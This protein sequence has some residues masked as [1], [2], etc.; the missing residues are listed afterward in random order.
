MID[1]LK[2]FIRSRFFLG[3]VVI[4]LQFAIL[5]AILSWLFEVFV[6]IV[7][8]A[9][10]FY[11]VV[12]LYILNRDEIPENKLPWVVI[13]MVIPIFGSFLFLLLSNNKASKKDYVRFEKSAKKI[14][15]HLTQTN[16]IDKLKE[17]DVDAYAQAKYLQ[18]GA[19][20]PV[21]DRSK[22]TYYPLGEDFHADLVKELKSAKSFIFMEYFIVQEG[23]MWSPIFEVLKEKVKQGVEVYMMYDDL[24]CIAT[25]PEDFY[26]QMQKEGI[27]C[28]PCNKFKPILSHI[29]NNRDHRKITVIDGKVGFTGG[30]NLADEY[31][32]AYVKHGH[33]KDTAVKI[34]GEAVKSL[35][36][37]FISLWN[38]QNERQLDCDKYLF[39]SKGGD[40]GTGYVIPFGD[41]PSPIDTEDVGKTVY[42]NMLNC[43]KNYVYI[44]TPYLICDREL[45]NAMCN[46]ARRGVDVRIIT[47]HIPDKK[48]VFLMTRSNYIKLIESCV[49]VYEYTPGFIHAK[50]FVSDDKF[51]VCGTINLDY[52]SL[53][54]HFEC[55]AWMYNT[56]SIADMKDDFENTLE[57]SQAISKAQ[58]ELP[59]L[60]KLF[61]EIMKVFSPL[62]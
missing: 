35:S 50:S 59:F 45:L 19:K 54:H 30:I 61:A 22:T 51:A 1:A 8:L 16:N 46:A 33:W 58:A 43:A 24:G 56:E 29:H 41:S 39:M 31:I 28:V 25:L 13:L 5:V 32:N 11:F 26:E 7:V 47:P 55:G 36:A 12:L 4:L 40:K 14:R 15:P 57:K 6:P 9:W 23:K 38:M 60:E 20:V 21:F 42:I 10:I 44:T 3:A 62:L 49:K 2:K 27:N 18:V 17:L 34:E 52:R 53:V 48:A 37:L